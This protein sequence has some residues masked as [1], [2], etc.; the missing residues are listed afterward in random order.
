MGVLDRS[1][2]AENVY[3]RD[4]SR[5]NNS[6]VNSAN[7]LSKQRSRKGPTPTA[8]A[9]RDTGYFFFKPPDVGNIGNIT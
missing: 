8:T 2:L 9:R 3:L 1:R 7:C 6:A 4:P 5:F